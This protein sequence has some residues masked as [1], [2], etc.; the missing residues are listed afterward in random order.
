MG[1]W[2]YFGKYILLL[3]GGGLML[4]DLFPLIGIAI[5]SNSGF[6]V[7]VQSVVAD[8][9]FGSTFIVG[10]ILAFWSMYTIN[11]PFH[12]KIIIP[13]INSTCFYRNSLYHSKYSCKFFHIFC[14]NNI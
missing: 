7:T 6:P 5:R 13:L 14:S 10:M 2:S 1:F 3:I 12:K 9:M 4:T 11:Q 8:L